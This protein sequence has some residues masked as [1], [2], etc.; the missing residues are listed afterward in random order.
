MQQM[1]FIARQ[2]LSDKATC[3]DLTIKAN[4]NHSF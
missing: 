1:D 3:D 4:T 2:G